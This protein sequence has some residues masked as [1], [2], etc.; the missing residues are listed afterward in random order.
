MIYLDNAATSYPKPERVLRELDRCVRH[1][2][3]N[4]GRSSHTL[5]LLASEKVYEARERIADLLGYSYPERVV[6]TLN[7]THALNLA[8]KTS[9]T[10]SCHV[11]T[12]DIEHNS[13]I[14]PLEKLKRTIGISYSS[15]KSGVNIEAEINRLIRDD[16]KF[17]IS[18]LQSNVSGE[19]VL[20]SELS[21]A[22][23]QHNLKLIVDASQAIGHEDINIKDTPCDILCAPGHK[24]LFGIQGSGVMVIT[25]ED[26]RDS[27][28]EG[29]SGSDS[30]SVNMPEM[31]PER[32]EAGTVATP[33]IATLSEGVGFISEVG[34]SEIKRKLSALGDMLYDRLSEIKSAKIYGGFH[35]GIISFNI[36]GVPADALAKRL[37]R[38]G[39][40]VRAGLHC[41][42]SAHK[43]LGTL[44]C[45][46][47]RVSLS[48]LNDKR[49]IE[50]FYKELRTILQ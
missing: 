11:I 23:K 1:Y 41:A 5:S 13:V 34:I 27:F 50:G 30:M 44:S 4:P 29:G 32:Y 10:D 38:A 25:D 39:I 7:A 48:Y 28:I 35:S 31:L 20:L 33:A 14:R 37:D 36:D 43:K 18:T 45:G 3:G 21:K 24:G 12:S 40:C 6:F 47:V 8:I 9:I 19:K 46:T 2:C 49:D 17:I 16:T 15:F 22:A 42:P 26:I